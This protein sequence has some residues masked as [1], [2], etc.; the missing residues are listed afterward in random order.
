MDPD[1]GSASLHR[2]PRLLDQAR[3]KLRTLHCSYRMEQQY[4]QWIQRFIFFH[5]KRHPRNMGAPEV[6]AFPAKTTLGF[7][8][9]PTSV[10]V[11]AISAHSHPL[12]EVPSRSP[13]LAGVMPS[14]CNSARVQAFCPVRVRSKNRAGM[15]PDSTSLKT[16]SFGCPAKLLLGTLRETRLFLAESVQ[17][18]PGRKR[19]RP[20]RPHGKGR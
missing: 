6:A 14:S 11:K 5:G 10:A 17:R 9:K 19:N 7:P 3:D 16:G 20:E 2:P 18:M 1:K 15:S 13:T 12:F 8:V 4:L